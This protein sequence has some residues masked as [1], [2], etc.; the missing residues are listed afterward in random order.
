VD[1]IV[2]IRTNPGQRSCSF[3]L[4]DPQLDYKAKLAELA[5]SNKHLAGFEVQD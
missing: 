3:R 5:E 1:G 4:E 2:D